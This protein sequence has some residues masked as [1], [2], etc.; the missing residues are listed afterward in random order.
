MKKTIILLLFILGIWAAQAMAQ[1]QWNVA[2]GRSSVNFKVKHLIFSQVEGKFKTFEGRLVTPN[3]DLTGAQLEAI[4]RIDSIYTGNQDRD[5][6]LYS[7]DFFAAEKYPEM[8]FKSTT[9]TKTN[10][11][12]IYTIK[13]DLTIR[14]VTKSVELTAKYV[15]VKTLA[16]GT[17]RM[18]LTATG[19]VNRFDYGLK[20]NE[21]METGKAIVGENVDISFNA[22]FVKDDNTLVAS[23]K[24]S[25]ET[26]DHSIS[27]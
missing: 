25:G 16:N 14:G 17:T 27:D 4:V 1:E 12:N 13:G 26:P 6:H 5:K 2:S 10:Q 11:P 8:V 20:W 9:I 15:G 24:M 7:Q 18:E 21:L 23:A 19:S 22:S 3:Q